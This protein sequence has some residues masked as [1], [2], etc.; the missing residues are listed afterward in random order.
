MKTVEISVERFEDLIKS[1]TTIHLIK[2]M[3][4]RTDG[5][6]L[7]FDTIKMILG[8]EEGER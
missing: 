2:D 5:S 1:E 8:V 6:Y 4:E 3:F 7:A